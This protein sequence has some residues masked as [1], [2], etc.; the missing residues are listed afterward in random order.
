MEARV[1]KPRSRKD[2]DVRRVHARSIRAEVGVT[3]IVQHDVNDIGTARSRARAREPRGLRIGGDP[4][5][6]SLK[7]AHGCHGP[8][9]F[10]LTVNLGHMREGR[11]TNS[12]EEPGTKYGH[13]RYV[14]GAAVIFLGL[15]PKFAGR[16]R[17]WARERT[18]PRRRAATRTSRSRWVRVVMDTNVLIAAVRS[19]DGASREFFIR[20]WG[21]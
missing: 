21:Y 7:T 18:G 6:G 17:S 15:R 10:S 9:G 13:A 19:P 12:N 1:L 5:E 4:P 11:Q 2:V 14:N 16:A 8:A 3:G 20:K